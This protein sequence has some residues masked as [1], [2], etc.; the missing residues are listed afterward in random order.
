M[1]SQAMLIVLQVRNRDGEGIRRGRRQ[2]LELLLM[3]CSLSGCWLL[4]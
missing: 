1:Q 3:F 2:A 4:D